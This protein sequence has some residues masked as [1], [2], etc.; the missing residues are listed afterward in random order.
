M[1]SYYTDLAIAN[2][3]PKVTPP[4]LKILDPPMEHLSQRQLSLAPVLLS[5]TWF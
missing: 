1:F 2:V 5:I 4:P 3:V